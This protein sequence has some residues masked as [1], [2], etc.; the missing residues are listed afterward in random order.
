MKHIHALYER[1]AFAMSMWQVKFH[2]IFESKGS[3]FL[4]M[5]V[6]K[7]NEFWNIINL[8]VTWVY[9]VSCYYVTLI[10]C[11]ILEKQFLHFILVFYF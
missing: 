10:E 2:Y 3:V 8:K 5:A 6:Q 11:G 7:Q 4:L 1:D 9:V